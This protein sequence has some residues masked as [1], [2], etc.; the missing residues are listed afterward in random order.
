VRN[1][2]HPGWTLRGLRIYGRE[3]AGT[4]R[5]SGWSHQIRGLLKMAPDWIAPSGLILLEI[6]ASQG[7]RAVDLAH[8]AFP[9][10][11]VNLSQDL[12]GR[13]RLLEIEMPQ[14]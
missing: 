5:W 4:Q 9:Q 1:L 12:A 2:P 14:A 7:R 13:D 3:G 10:A 8:D 11:S 6:E